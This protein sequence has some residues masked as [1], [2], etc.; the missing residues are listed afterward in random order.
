MKVERQKEIK[1]DFKKYVNHLFEV[2][3]GLPEMNGPVFSAAF[4]GE[5]DASVEDFILSLGF[6][7]EKAIV[8]I[9]AFQAID[10][11]EFAKQ[12]E[13]ESDYLSWFMEKA[14][15][16]TQIREKLIQGDRA[17]A[18]NDFCNKKLRDFSKKHPKEMRQLYD[19]VEE[20]ESI[21]D[22]NKDLDQRI[23]RRFVSDWDNSKI[24]DI[25]FDQFT[26]AWINDNILPALLSCHKKKDEIRQIFVK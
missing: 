8:V 10:V 9:A 21:L 11:Q 24:Q 4:F 13:L 1:E 3:S 12:I 16:F 25:T 6:K 15:I 18:E 23:A 5:Q 20:G 19:F 26:S 7:K 22:L 2:E 14:E 17:V